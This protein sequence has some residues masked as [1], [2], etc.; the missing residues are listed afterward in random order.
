MIGV[1][2]VTRA[3]TSCGLACDSG[4]AATS[5]RLEI[6]H[7]IDSAVAHELVEVGGIEAEEL[8]HLVVTETVLQHQ[9]PHEA[10]ARTQVGSG[11][12]DA[13]PVRRIYGRQRSSSGLLDSSN[14]ARLQ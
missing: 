9:L 4:R 1:L 13:E 2:K 14:Y 7:G 12:L 5:P 6:V 11:R 10:F 8:A 3:E